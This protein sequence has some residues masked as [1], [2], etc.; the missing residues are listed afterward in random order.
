MNNYSAIILERLLHAAPKRAAVIRKC[1]I[2][3][4][5]PDLLDDDAGKFVGASRRADN[6]SGNELLRN[7]R[8]QKRRRLILL[9]D[10]TAP[11]IRHDA[12]NLEVCFG[13]H[14]GWLGRSLLRRGFL[15]L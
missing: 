10:T 2:P 4:H 12:D 7:C 8:R 6:N 9:I 14:S 11:H 3:I 1:D 13:R 5:G 15:G